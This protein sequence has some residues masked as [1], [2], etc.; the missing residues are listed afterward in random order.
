M[1]ILLEAN[2]SVI[3]VLFKFRTTKYPHQYPSI[4]LPVTAPSVGFVLIAT[5]DA[6]RRLLKWD[7]QTTVHGS[8]ER[9]LVV[10]LQVNGLIV[11]S[12]SYDTN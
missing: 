2:L 4:N 11:T 1:T 7:L 10:V 8:D 9:L 3:K 12:F 5:V 6:N